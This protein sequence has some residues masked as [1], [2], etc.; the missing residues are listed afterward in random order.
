M[1][2]LT[3]KATLSLAEA[4]LTQTVA[5]GADAGVGMRRAVPVPVGQPR[6]AA[7]TRSPNRHLGHSRSCS[8]GRRTPHLPPSAPPHVPTGLANPCVLH[9]HR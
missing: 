4:R 2:A 3:D 8:T 9:L 5:D 1:R 7:P 6:H